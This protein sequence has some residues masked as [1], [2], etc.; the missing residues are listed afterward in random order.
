MFTASD[1][2]LVP[3]KLSCLVQAKGK[4]YFKFNEINVHEFYIFA[5]EFHVA[6]DP[7]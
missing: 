2:T 5:N 4:P 1:L 3:P 6:W 7:K